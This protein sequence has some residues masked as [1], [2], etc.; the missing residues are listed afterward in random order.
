LPSISTLSWLGVL[1]IESFPALVT[2]HTHPE[3]KRAAPAALNCSRNFAK[4]PNASLIA[5]PTL[6]PGSPPAFGAIICQNMEWFQ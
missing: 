5:F 2:S 1:V 6:P 3:P 4:S